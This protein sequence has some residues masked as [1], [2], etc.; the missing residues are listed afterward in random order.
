MRRIVPDPSQRSAQNPH[1]AEE[2]GQAVT[3]ATKDEEERQVLPSVRPGAELTSF[4]FAGVQ[5]NPNAYVPPAF[6]KATGQ[7]A[8]A[9]RIPNAEPTSPAAVAHI[10]LISSVESSLPATGQNSTASSSIPIPAQPARTTSDTATTTEKAQQ[11]GATPA[12]APKTGVSPGK[13][14]MTA[15]SPNIKATETATPDMKGNK[16]LEAARTFKDAEMRKA[17]AKRQAVQKSQRTEQLK[18]LADWSRGFKVS[19]D[20]LH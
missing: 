8:V 18:A 16:L 20:G 10:G 7:G 6:R 14:S 9:P 5:R 12:S 1:I 13:P 15:L 3:D 4:R 2:R 17:E 19:L 11:A